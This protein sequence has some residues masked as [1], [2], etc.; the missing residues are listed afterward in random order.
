MAN[1]L[2]FVDK[3]TYQQLVFSIVL[4]FFLLLPFSLLAQSQRI[5]GLILD[6][7]TRE[8]IIGATVVFNDGKEGTVANLDGKFS[9]D[10][11][12]F[13]AKIV[14][15]SLGYTPQ[16]LTITD[17]KPVTILLRERLNNLNEVVVVAYGTQK[18]KELTG[19]ISSVNKEALTRSS[20]AS[21]L[22]QLLG[23]AVA[24]LNVSQSSGLPGASANIRIRGGNSITGGNEPLYVVDGIIVYKDNSNTTT[25]IGRLEG[26]LNPLASI[27]PNDI[28]SIEVLKDVSATAIYGSRGANGVILIT[29]KSGKKGRNN[30]EYQYSI[31]WQSAAKKLDLL[32]ARQWGEL[33]QEIATAQDIKETGLT[34]EKVAQLGEGTNWQDA[35]LRTALTQ[36]HQVTI[37][38]GDEKTR[39]LVSGN[40]SDQDGILRNT[41]FKRYSGRLNFERDLFS[42]FTIGVNASAS[43]LEQNGLSKFSGLFVNGVSNTLDY[44]LRTPQVVSIYD[45]NGNYNYSNPFEKGDLRFGERTVNGLSDLLN[46]VSQSKNNTFIGNFFA[47]YTII[48]GLVAK[49]NAGSN[50]SNTTQN[51]FAP[52]TSIAG[53]L[54]KGYGSIGNKK[55]DSW[56]YEY[57]LN[58]TK[59]LTPD[60][61]I[62]ALIGY[63]TQT[64]KIDYAIASSSNFANEQL[65]YYNLQ[66]GSTLLAPES[67]G[68][69]SVLNSVLGR[70]NYSYLG[71]YNLTATFRGDGSSRFSKNHKWG[72]F[73]SVG[74]SW[75]ADEESF[76]KGNKVISDLKLRGS[77]GTVGN[78]E[79][80]DY[81]YEDTYLKKTYSFNGQL[82]TAYGRSNPANE[83]LKWE[84][85]VQYNVGFD[86]NI[87]HGRLGFVG[88]VYYKKTSDLLLNVPVEITTGFSSVLRNVGNVTNKGVEFAVNSSIVESKDFGWTLSA[89]IAKNVNEITN[90]G[91]Q[92]DYYLSGNTIV[93]VGESL[94]SF[95]GI[96]FDG[97]VQSGDDLT[98]VPSPS[99]KP[100]V[101]YG[102]AKYVDQDH[103]G[104]ITQENDRV[105]LGSIQPDFTYGVSTTVRY[106]ALSLFA[107]F[108]GSQGNEI[109][110]SLRQTLETPT[111]SYNLSSVLLD[112]WTAERP[113]TTVPKANATSVTYLDSRYVEDASFFRLKNVTL[114]YDLPVKITAAPTTKFRVFANA[115]NLF[116]LTKYKGYDPEIAN[117][118]DAGAYPT[119][120]TFSFGVNISY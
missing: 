11:H 56:Q 60:H 83:D 87:L 115:Q 41:D 4:S 28:E 106:K 117:G 78:Q 97:V 31:G 39:Y 61:L 81:K 73:P 95:Y 29:T 79:I 82:V 40:F 98:K 17:S 49:I 43:K 85:T 13:P 5:E 92:L 14:V 22:D 89:N 42:N 74:F 77:I 63:T 23:G 26:G 105:V 66:G 55:F 19:A 116:T 18:R 51:F 34:A 15:S 50:I 107:A 102:D 99:W 57:T 64:T 32:N 88:D 108:Q 33:Y 118:I 90:L 109:Y 12:S 96:V 46:S 2:N 76:L 62:D 71:R 53:F 104:K 36:S 70:V 110:N 35:A 20:A 101:A 69:E 103:D 7:S 16:E 25:G 3:R 91:D 86:L 113:S 120:R 44:I 21:S 27:N 84:Q 72:Y 58:Y 48:P 38:G 54:P 119:A 9:F 47:R 37:S 68:S 112:R 93:K 52:S 65:G 24:G 10:G 8:P 114:S 100:T 111:T 30:I 59:Q 75:N 67:G 94:G 1:L 80:G 6:G 45:A